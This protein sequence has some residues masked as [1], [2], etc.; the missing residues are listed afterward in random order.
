ME[1]VCES[2][3]LEDYL[4][5][6]NEVNYSN[7]TIKGKIEELFN[8]TQTELEKAKAAFEYVRDEIVHSWDI[9]GQLETCKASDVLKYKEKF[10]EKDYPVIYAKPH[11]KTLDVL[12]EHTDAI[13][14]YQSFLPQY[15]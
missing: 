15:L 2:D 7:S 9:Q 1:L 12:E 13:E 5:E 10:D 4:L 11:S 6:L 8:P 14:M 3:Q